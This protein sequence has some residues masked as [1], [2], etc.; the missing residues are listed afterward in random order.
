MCR[1]H[2][3]SN[4]YSIRRITLS[5][6]N[7]C[8]YLISRRFVKWIPACCSSRCEPMRTFLM[9]HRV[10]VDFCSW[11]SA[12]HRRSAQA[13]HVKRVGRANRRPQMG[14]SGAED[15]ERGSVSWVL[16]PEGRETLKNPWVSVR[17]EGHAPTRG[18][19]AGVVRR[20]AS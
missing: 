1:T 4:T 13:I 20:T 2:H 5:C 9:A 15:D 19:G 10:P 6:L 8:R 17:R 18:R 3:S 7:S 12:G 11:R 16:V 14:K